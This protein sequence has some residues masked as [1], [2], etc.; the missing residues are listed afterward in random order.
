MCACFGNFGC[1]C[2]TG[3]GSFWLSEFLKIRRLKSLAT[4]IFDSKIFEISNCYFFIFINVKNLMH[5]VCFLHCWCWRQILKVYDDKL[6]RFCSKNHWKVHS[7]A[8]VEALCFC[9]Y[10]I[11]GT[12]FYRSLWLFMCQIL[13]TLFKFYFILN[14]LI[15]FLKL[16]YTIF[17]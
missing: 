8:L 2:C 7:I 4:K 14:F 5:W 1:I 11:F 12:K 16:K 6:L 9:K 15:N 17:L 3:N 13:Q 10:R